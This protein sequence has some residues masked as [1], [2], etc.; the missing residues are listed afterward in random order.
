M[1]RIL[2]ILLCVA[3]SLCVFAGCDEDSKKNDVQETQQGAAS[4]TDEEIIDKSVEAFSAIKSVRVDAKTENVIAAQGQTITTNAD[5]ITDVDLENKIQYAKMTMKQNGNTV[6]S[7]TYVSVD[8]DSVSVYVSNDG[9]WMKQ[10]QEL[11]YTRAKELG[12]DPASSGDMMNLYLENLKV[13]GTRTE[14]TVNGKDC[15]VFKSDVDGSQLEMLESSALKDTINQLMRAGITESELSDILSSMGK[16]GYEIA[17]EKETFLPVRLYMDMGEAMNTLMD[18]LLKKSGSAS[19][20][21]V[22]KCIGDTLYTDYD[23]IKPIVISDAALN[24][25][26]QKMY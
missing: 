4:L 21:K 17:I 13:N 1:K 12:L 19:D 18:A 5:V 16:V 8:D 20:I 7:E 11:D 24:G 25:K 6:V 10:T 14:A 9:K 15:Y 22:E 2:S 26:E 23:S 3:L